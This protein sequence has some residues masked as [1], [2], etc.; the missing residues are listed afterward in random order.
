MRNIL[1]LLSLFILVS[2]ANAQYKKEYGG[3]VGTSNYLGDIGGGSKEGR[4]NSPLDLKI[5]HER[6]SL[7]GYTRLKLNKNFSVKGS[8]SYIRLVGKDANSSNPQRNAR[9]LSFK[10]NVIELIATGEWNFYQQTKMAP[11]VA[12][13]SK[14]GKKQRVDFRAYAFTGFGG[15]YFS[16]KA[17]LLGK[18][19]NLR[20]YKTEGVAYKPFTWAVPLGLGVSYTLN[21]K[22]RIGAELGYRITGSDWIDDV[23]GNYAYSYDEGAKGYAN[24]KSGKFTDDDVR[25]ALAN[26]TSEIQSKYADNTGYNKNLPIGANYDTYLNDK[27]VLVGSPRGGNY[28]PD[29]GK[30]SL[31]NIINKDGYMVMNVSVGY[32]L[33]GKNKY[34]KSK[35]RNI[36]NRRKVVKKKTRAKF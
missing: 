1:V 6:F 15:V 8:L 23:S 13:L 26:R 28:N 31:K 35:Y 11:R 30:S 19:Y 22:L 3:G 4:Q 27:N 9:N 5:K 32:V 20:K 34:Y 10:S 29:L 17:E 14:G 12:G 16:S 36:V 21:K 7:N 2:S 24:V 18:S 25:N 33:K